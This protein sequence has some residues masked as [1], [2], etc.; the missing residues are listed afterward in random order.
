MA[1]IVTRSEIKHPP[2]TLKAPLETRPVET[3]RTVYH[4]QLAAYKTDRRAEQGWR[5]LVRKAPELL[6][7]S[8]HVIVTPDPKFNSGGLRRLR[9]EAQA[10][11][12][13]AKTL[14]DALK[15]RHISCLIVAS[16]TG[17]PRMFGVAGSTPAVKTDRKP[18][19]SQPLSLAIAPAIA[20]PAPTLPTRPEAVKIASTANSDSARIV[21]TWQKPV[22]YSV[23]EKGSDLLV[24]FDRPLGDAHVAGITSNLRNWVDGVSTGY[25]TLLLQ[26]RPGVRFAVNMEEARFSIDL[27]S[28]PDD[29]PIANSEPQPVSEPGNTTQQELMLLRAQV[30]I[31]TG[32]EEDA[33]KLLVAEIRRDPDYPGTLIALADLENQAGRWREALKLYD[34]ALIRLP[35]DEDILSARRS[36]VRDRAP[37]LK[38]EVEHGRIGSEQT[39]NILRLSGQ[40]SAFETLRLG[41]LSEIRQTKAGEVRRVAGDISDFKGERLR[42]E[43]FAD[44]ELMDGRRLR[45]ALLLGPET[46]GLGAAYI[47]PDLRGET[48]FAAEFNR[49]SWDFTE[50]FVDRGVRHQIGARR[51]HR[52]FPRLAGEMAASGRIY[53]I[54]GDRN[55]ASSF[56][57]DGELQYLL[58]PG[59]P[60]LSV[61]YRV[62]AEY[63]YT[64]ESRRDQSGASFNPIP[65][66]SREIHALEA[67]TTYDLSDEWRVRAYSGY[68]I[69]R[70]A[71]GDFF[72]GVGLIHQGEGRL[73]ARLFAE[74]GLSASD[75]GETALLVGASLTLRF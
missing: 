75:T 32:R 71:S 20:E 45:G 34:R 40:Y 53:G 61:G 64:I 42:G 66:V 49:P 70:Y 46:V 11:R 60:S 8:G 51:E 28:T 5:E 12:S 68:G 41:F 38:I 74:R 65:L 10:R 56:A 62:D 9:S 57:L 69:D 26:A 18:I 63:R 33:S 19:Y 17:K 35:R 52:F 21:L 48:R 4:V 73:Q 13:D 1:D 6:G 23:E 14:C 37:F 30:L 59:S 43:I 22:G 29:K 24:R 47:A 27:L 44:R 67:S 7:G 15:R 54:D 31:A 25:D 3:A 39:E 72:A 36:I 2:I 16:K 50:G 58:L 55:V